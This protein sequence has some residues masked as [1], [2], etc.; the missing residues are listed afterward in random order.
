[1]L[2]SMLSIK[3]VIEVI[4][5]AVEQAG[6][7]RTRSKALR[8]LVDQI[9][10]G[11]VEMISVLHAMAPDIDEF[12]ALLEP[13]S[14]DAEVV[15]GTIGPVV[16]VHTGPR[17]DRHR[18]DST[19]ATERRTVRGDDTDDDANSRA[20]AAAGD[21]AALD[22][23]LAPPHVARARASAAGCS[24]TPTTRSTRRKKR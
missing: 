13:R 7:V 9:P 22:A 24:A 12:L 2:G 5:G 19:T 23:L 21:A 3:P 11:K 15:V 14:P 6:K 4:D 17:V 20:A 1:M 18:V 10:D 8:F 16:G